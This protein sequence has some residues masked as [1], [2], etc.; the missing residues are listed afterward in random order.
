MP[1]SGHWTLAGQGESA[2][3][4]RQLRGK[5]GGTTPEIQAHAERCGILVRLWAPTVFILSNRLDSYAEKLG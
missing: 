3:A 5:T 1:I 4:V 2:A